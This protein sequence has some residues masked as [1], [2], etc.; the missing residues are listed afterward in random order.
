MYDLIVIGGGPAGGPGAEKA[1]REGYK[2]L[3]IEERHLGGVCLNEGCIP[4]KQLLY[5]AK[6]YHHAKDS[7]SYG[8]KA[9]DVTFDLATA[10]ARKNKL[11][12][13]LRKAS[14]SSKKRHHVDVVFAHGEVMP[15]QGDAFHVKAGDQV[16]EG[17]R[18]MLC[19][20][21]E[22]IRPPI[23]GA[24][25]QFVFTNREMLDINFIPQKLVIIGGGIIG[26]EFAT[27][28]SEVGSQVTVIEMLPNIAGNLDAE[29]RAILQ[30]DLEKKGVAFTLN[31]KVTAVEDHA[32]RYEEAG[33]P[34]QSVPADIVLMSVGR[35][36]VTKNIGLEN[37]HVE[38]DRGAVKTDL[39][40][41]TNVASVFAAGDINGKVMLAHTATREAEVAVDTMLG[42]KSAVRY[43]TIPSVIYTHPEVATVG[44]T[45]EQAVE[46][47]YDA[48]TGVL[49]MTFSGRYMAENDSGRG[50]VKVVA[51]KQFGTIL[52][53]HM[54]G[55][56]CSEMIHGAA[57]MIE[58]ELRVADVRDIVF[59]HPTTAEVMKD[60]IMEI[61]L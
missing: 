20:G 14:E 30:K 36:P 43:D 48:V 26:L 53:V 61:K 41:R 32:V 58:A 25:R 8:V 10:M 28:F 31:A 44:L 45:K 29:I 23:P 47:G 13:R 12:E 27:F 16:H 22:A 54:I 52:G 55:A 6:L 9:Q 15:M 5:C 33:S 35:R 4:S 19:T 50:I 40:C 21:S 24:D 56:E 38:L 7:E 39:S 57:V 3:L 11:I 60:A 2:T 59:A 51:E 46:K 49:P 37:L 1:A 17:K 42:H 34:A 18:L